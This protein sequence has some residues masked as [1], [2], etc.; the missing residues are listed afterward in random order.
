LTVYYVDGLVFLPLYGEADTG[1]P[2]A[3]VEALKA[4]LAANKT[5][6]RRCRPGSGNT[7]C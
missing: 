5:R 6:G 7:A 2:V 1:I 4:A 3:A